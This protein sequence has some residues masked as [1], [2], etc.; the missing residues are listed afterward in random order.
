MGTQLNM[1]QQQR[2]PGVSGANAQPPSV[3]RQELR[4]LP[5]AP[6]CANEQLQTMGRQEPRNFA[7]APQQSTPEIRYPAD[8]P[9]MLPQEQLGAAL[10]AAPTALI[11]AHVQ[12]RDALA[13][14]DNTLQEVGRIQ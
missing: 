9:S 4:S 1:Q 3:G 5:Q 12:L 13:D 7:Q 14:A 6:P 8:A 10:L 2:F 11:A